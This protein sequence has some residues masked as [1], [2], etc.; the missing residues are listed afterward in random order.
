MNKTISA[1][2]AKN[3]FGY[4]LEEVYVKGRSI[5]ITKNN[6][7]VAKITPVYSHELTNSTPSL[8]LTDKE[9]DRVKEGV[10]EFRET[11]KFSY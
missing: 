1:S 2:K 10:K 3:N 7:P 9:Y 11:F 5:T 6:K 4:L 8:A